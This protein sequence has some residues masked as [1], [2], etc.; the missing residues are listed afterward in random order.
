MPITIPP[1]TRD[2][3][4]TD[5]GTA[6]RLGAA[7]HVIDPP[8]R[9]WVRRRRAVPGLAASLA[10]HVVVVLTFIALWQTLPHDLTTP[11]SIP[12]EIVSSVPGETGAPGEKTE[13][14][15]ADA[16]GD[17]ADLKPA[18]T[19]PEPSPPKPPAPKS[20]P[21]A[22]ALALPAL[23]PAP[24]PAPAPAPDP[25]PTPDPAPASAPPSPA[26]DPA[27]TP[28]PP[29][30]P[31]PEPPKPPAPATTGTEKAPS[32]PDAKAPEEPE[33]AVT[34][35]QP[36]DRP[37]AVAETLKEPTPDAAE[38]PPAAAP[39][40]LTTPEADSSVPAPAENP[41]PADTK[42]ATSTEKRAQ[43]AAASL[44]AALPMGSLGM[45]TTFRSILSSQ[46]TSA[47]QEY[48]GVVF[49]SLS[50]ATSA[51]A[52]EARRRRLHG[53]VAVRISLSPTGGLDGVA[54]AQSSG[55]A[56]VDAL[57]L[58]LVRRAAPFPPPPPGTARQFTP[59][60][61]IGDE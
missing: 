27:P 5:D 7:V 4:V 58:D 22:D 33:A 40:V 23:P 49:G 44:S 34:Q 38:P 32:R 14:K 15:G 10:F 39:M 31:T 60:I 2:A 12:V 46:G 45:P 57:A 19:P 61:A 17:A 47:S 16:G 30:S 36:D 9:A 35:K 3:I 50:R 41:D 21:L 54:V 59:L 6:P 53:M 48:R 13:P 28:I 55:S 26:P 11:E 52:E 18:I 37:N 43:A 29:P 1:V 25:S 51:V 42:A 24:A 20:D 56:E 8:P